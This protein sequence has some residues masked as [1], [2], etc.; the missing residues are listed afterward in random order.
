MLE[1]GPAGKVDVDPE[2]EECKERVETV[3]GKTE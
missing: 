1:L 3:L 2:D